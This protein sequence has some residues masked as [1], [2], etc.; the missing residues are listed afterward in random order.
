MQIAFTIFDRDFQVGR[1]GLLC[2]CR[3]EDQ[4]PGFRNRYLATDDH[5]DHIWGLRLGMYIVVMLVVVYSHFG[6]N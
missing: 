1:D 5:H 2:K 3:I 4:L 6:G